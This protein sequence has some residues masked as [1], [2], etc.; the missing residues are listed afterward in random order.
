MKN[1]EAALLMIAWSRI[2]SPLVDD[3]MRAEA[4]QALE[5]PDS[6]QHHN[7]EY[8]TLFHAGS[9]QPAV[10]TLL[11]AALMADGASA[12][13]DWLRVIEHLGLKWNDV[14]LPPDQLGAACE[15]CACAIER[16]ESVLVD[17]LASRYFL[18][19]CDAAEQ[20]LAAKK[21]PLQQLARAFSQD[22]K[23]LASPA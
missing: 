6:Y 12:R 16:E 23:N 4:W 18:P 7:T 22:I 20:T 11:H 13:E 1:S 2:W 17:M 3:E 15:I 14:H 19:W 10:S 9:P 5:L 8:W 21:S